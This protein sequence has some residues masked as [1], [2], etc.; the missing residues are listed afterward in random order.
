MKSFLGAVHDRF[1]F[2]RRVRLL[3]DALAKE[4]P[5]NATVLDVGAGEGSIALGVQALRPD[6]RIE[7]IDVFVRPNARI[8][9]TVYDGHTF[10]FSDGTFDVVMFVD[11][12]HHT[13]EPNHLLT[14]AARVAR[15]RVVIKDH[16]FDGFLA[17]PTLRLMDWVGNR[18]RDVPLPYNYLEKKT[19]D[20]IISAAGLQCATWRDSLGLYP[21]PFGLIFDRR[22]HFVAGLAH[23][24]RTHFRA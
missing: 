11:V 19:W 16:L 7:A 10:P 17:W 18:D 24:A 5:Q 23:Q 3:A 20:E 21:M 8:P 4:L 14:E 22:L 2:K 15:R 13:T 1:V 12:L 6:V 9:V